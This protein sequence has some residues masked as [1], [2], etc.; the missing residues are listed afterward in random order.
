[1]EK[2]K[3]KPVLWHMFGGERV[4]PSN[5]RMKMAKGPLSTDVCIFLTTWKSSHLCDRYFPWFQKSLFSTICNVKMQK[6]N[7]ESTCNV[8]SFQGKRLWNPTQ[9]FYLDKELHTYNSNSGFM[10]KEMNST[11]I[12]SKL[13]MTKNEFL[14]GYLTMKTCVGCEFGVI[15]T[16]GLFCCIW[17]LDALC[18]CCHRGKAWFPHRWMKADATQLA[19]AA[20]KTPR[21]HGCTPLCGCKRQW[22]CKMLSGKTCICSLAPHR[23]F[24]LILCTVSQIT[25]VW[26][27]QWWASRLTG[28][29]SFAGPAPKLM[30]FFCSMMQIK[31]SRPQIT[32]ASSVW[33]SDVTW[34][35]PSNS[36][37]SLPSSCTKHS[38]C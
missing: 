34:I 36:S 20:Y 19:G 16:H 31:S 32:G 21:K 28:C 29:G 33:L 27:A 10:H 5:P 25:D 22:L 14:F 37:G 13:N 12:R 1:M 3:M 38:W 26:R 18:R 8:K 6:Y 23:L 9:Q 4:K 35:A 17:K 15:K 30:S 24:T 11:E 2:E 7:Y